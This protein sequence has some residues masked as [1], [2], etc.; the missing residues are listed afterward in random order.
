MCAAKFL[1]PRFMM[2]QVAKLEV[3][4]TANDINTI[5]TP[6]LSLSWWPVKV[7]DSLT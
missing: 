6:C 3:S 5:A 4:S 7:L 1:L 2:G